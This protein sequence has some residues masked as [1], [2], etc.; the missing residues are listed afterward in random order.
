MDNNC[1]SNAHEEANYK[2]L[3]NIITIFGLESILK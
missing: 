3:L 2:K 1:S